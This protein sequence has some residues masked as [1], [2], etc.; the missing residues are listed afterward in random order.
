[1]RSYQVNAFAIDQYLC[2][3]SNRRTLAF[4]TRNGLTLSPSC[5]RQRQAASLVSTLALR[6]GCNRSVV[7]KS[8]LLRGQPTQVGGLKFIVMRR[9][10]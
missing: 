8:W 4:R 2:W 6:R 3:L 7:T 5:C 1:M 10:A 9:W